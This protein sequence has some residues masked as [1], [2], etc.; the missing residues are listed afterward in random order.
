MY[1]CPVFNWGWVYGPFPYA[2]GG[3]LATSNFTHSEDAITLPISPSI[4][5]PKHTQYCQL[6]LSYPLPIACAFTLTH[7][8][9]VTCLCSRYKI[10]LSI[11]HLWCWGSCTCALGLALTWFYYPCDWNYWITI[12]PQSQVYF[13]VLAGCEV[14]MEID[15]NDG[16]PDLDSLTV[17]SH[18]ASNINRKRWIHSCQCHYIE[19]W[20]ISSLAWMRSRESAIDAHLVSRLK[21]S[22][23]NH[24]TMQYISKPWFSS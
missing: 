17:T 2:Q 10:W 13:S 15:L 8:H 3:S 16:V 5:Q 9:V 4:W 23:Q 22:A 6:H 19:S 20:W 18:T 24:G 12:A 1:Y 11:F 21:R 14:A 7:C